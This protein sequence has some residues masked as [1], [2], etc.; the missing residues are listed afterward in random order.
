MSDTTKSADT[1]PPQAREAL[2]AF[3][4]TIEAT[5]GVILFESGEYAPAV[6]EDWVDLGEAYMKA[7]RALDRPSVVHPDEPQYTGDEWNFE[8]GEDGSP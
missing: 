5:G 6:D 3:A 1:L 4:T 8:E 7:C 2:E